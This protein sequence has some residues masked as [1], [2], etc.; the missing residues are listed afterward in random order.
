MNV[1]GYDMPDD[2]YYHKEHVWVR[3]KGNKATVGFND[4]TQKMAGEISYVETP[5]EDDE[6]AQDDEVGTL[7]TGKWVGKMF[8]PVSGKVT[9][10]NEELMDD[11]T[12]INEDPYGKGWLFEIEMSNPEELE[13]LMKIEDASEWLKSEIDKHAE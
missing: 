9:A 10:V 11:P 12:L 6:V 5:F 4:F 1:Q 7:E 3:V 13:N 2:L 8:A